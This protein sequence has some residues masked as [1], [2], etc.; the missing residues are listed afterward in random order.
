MNG[1]RALIIRIDVVRKK[2]DFLKF[3]FCILIKFKNELILNLFKN[4]HGNNI[5][6]E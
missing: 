5:E 4:R 2:F 3:N 6:I 1:G